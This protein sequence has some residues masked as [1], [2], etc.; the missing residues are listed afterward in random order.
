MQIPIG[1]YAPK[2]QYRDCIIVD[3]KKY[4]AEKSV[5]KQEIGWMLIL[6]IA[7]IVWITYGITRL[8]DERWLH[9][10]TILAIPFVVLI[11]WLFIS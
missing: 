7:C 2:T 1:F 11:M 8:A 10:I 6:T 5:T 4:C 9:G 3:A